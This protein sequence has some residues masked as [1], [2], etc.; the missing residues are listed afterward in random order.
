MKGYLT[1]YYEKLYKGSMKSFLKHLKNSIDSE[2]GCFVVTANPE[3][4]MLGKRIPEMNSLLISKDTLLVPDGIGIIRGGQILGYQF[5]ERIPGV[6]ICQALFDYADSKYKSL[7]LFGATKSVVVS[8]ANQ[9]KSRYKGINL[10]G[11]CDGYVSDKEK[12]FEKI[13]SLNPDIVLVALGTPL[14]ELLIHEY[15]NSKLKGV[16]IG[17]GG[18]FDVLSGTKKRAPVFFIKHN[19]EWLYRITTEPKRLKRFFNNNVKFLFE[20]RKEKNNGCKS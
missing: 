2:T 11:F 9:I 1:Q 19:L 8:L 20:L 7:Y 18:S 4:L 14:Q 13:V 15:Y 12:I 5:E 3:I 17:V 6:E 10:L 16:Y